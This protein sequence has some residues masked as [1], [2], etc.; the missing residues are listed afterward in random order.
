MLNVVK[1]DETVKLQVTI[2]FESINTFV[3][4]SK[5]YAFLSWLVFLHVYSNHIFVST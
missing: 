2:M 4:S 1:V 5:A 3:D